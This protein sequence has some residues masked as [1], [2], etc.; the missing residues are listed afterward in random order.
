MW[1]KDYSSRGD[2]LTI[3]KYNLIFQVPL[4]VEGFEPPA[5][6][7]WHSFYRMQ[8]ENHTP[9]PNAQSS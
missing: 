4:D 6:H 1:K 7:M 8:S 9:R 5:F 2:E 3:Q